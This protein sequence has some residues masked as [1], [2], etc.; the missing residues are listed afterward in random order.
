MRIITILG[1]RVFMQWH[2]NRLECMSVEFC[3]P[4]SP[5]QAEEATLNVNLLKLLTV[6]GKILY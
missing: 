3:R 1:K 5:Q 4:A 2:T 6:V